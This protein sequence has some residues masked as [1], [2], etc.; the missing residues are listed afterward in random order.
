MSKSAVSIDLAGT[1]AVSILQLQEFGIIP[2]LPQGQKVRLAGALV[3]I[4]V[5]SIGEQAQRNVHSFR[6]FPDDRL[7]NIHDG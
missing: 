6:G 5:R 1:F 3:S 2:V 7:F 4:A